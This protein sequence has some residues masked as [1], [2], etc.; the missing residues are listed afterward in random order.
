MQPVQALTVGDSVR[1]NPVATSR[2]VTVTPGRAA[3]CSSVTRPLMLPAVCWAIAGTAATHTRRIETS[4]ILRIPDLLKKGPLHE[5]EATAA[6]EQN[7]G[8]NAAA[9]RADGRRI[10]KG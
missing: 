2:A 9:E 6:R 3:F 7:A 10:G 1:T 8:E 4:T 5:N